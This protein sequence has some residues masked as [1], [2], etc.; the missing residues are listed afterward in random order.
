MARDDFADELEVLCVSLHPIAVE[1]MTK[2]VSACPMH[3][4]VVAFRPYI[5]ATL[6]SGVRLFTRGDVSHT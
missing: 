2:H 5:V 4:F 3:R 1:T 6:L